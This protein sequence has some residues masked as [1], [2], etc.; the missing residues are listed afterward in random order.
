MKKFGNPDGRFSVE[1][2][3][4]I[5]NTDFG[6]KEGRTRVQIIDTLT[7]KTILWQSY[8]YFEHDFHPDCWRNGL[9]HVIQ[10]LNRELERNYFD[11]VI[12]LSEKNSFIC[13]HETEY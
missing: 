7:K 6:T 3:H 1:I 2:E 9:S 4:T 11:E 10:S 12:I 13:L 5:W 8:E